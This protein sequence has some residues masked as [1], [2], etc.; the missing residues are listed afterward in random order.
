VGERV[1]QNLPPFCFRPVFA[2]PECEKSFAWPEYRSLRTG[3]LATQASAME[4]STCSFLAIVRGHCGS[5]MKDRTGSVEMVPLLSCN[6]DILRHE[7]LFSIIGMENEAE[8]LL[9]RASIFA[10]PQNVENLIICLQHRASLSV[11]LKR[12]IRFLCSSTRWCEY[13]SVCPT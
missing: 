12:K 13:F 4:N 10:P 11:S 5:D 2:R 3:T 8:L 7:S 1:S 9:A 6:R